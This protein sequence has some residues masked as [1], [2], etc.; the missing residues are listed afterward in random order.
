MGNDSEA[1]T[2]KE[3][4]PA[5]AGCA[6]KSKSIRL[7]SVLWTLGAILADD[8]EISVSLSKVPCRSRLRS[9]PRHPQIPKL[10]PQVLTRPLPPPLPAADVLPCV[11][12]TGRNTSAKPSSSALSSA[13]SRAASPHSKWY[14]TKC[15][16]AMNEPRSTCRPSASHACRGGLQQHL[17]ARIIRDAEH[18]QRM[19]R[20]ECVHLQSSGERAAEPADLVFTRCERRPA[21][22]SAWRTATGRG[23]GETG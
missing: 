12:R 11:S 19:G 15:G 4:Q 23:V 14:S 9:R 16:T 10:V 3:Q 7:N 1:I 22:G 20:N 18:T 5:S 13:K 8:I 2:W 17:R 21:C 6:K